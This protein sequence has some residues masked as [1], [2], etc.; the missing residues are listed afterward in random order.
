[1][2]LPAPLKA[3]DALI[4]AAASAAGAALVTADDD[5]LRLPGLAG[6]LLRPS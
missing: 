4:A 3:P 2:A 5:F 1:V 6:E